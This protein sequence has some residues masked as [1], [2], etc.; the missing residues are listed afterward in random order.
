MAF[1]VYILKCANGKYYTGHTDDLEKRI[2][3]HQS[4]A[5]KGYTAEHSPVILMWSQDFPTRYEALDAEMKIK[6][7]SQA[8]KVALINGDWGRVSF[9]AKP[10]KKRFII[11][12]SV[13]TGLDTNGPERVALDMSGSQC[14]TLN[15]S[16]KRETPRSPI[17]L[18]PVA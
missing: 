11:H 8:K 15:T 2:G 17:V 18:S 10:P 4:G 3:Q 1:Y 12:Q 14:I 13:S 16:N 7:W 6:G 9:F 5:I